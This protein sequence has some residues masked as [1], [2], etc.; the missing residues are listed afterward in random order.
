LKKIKTKASLTLLNSRTLKSLWFSWK[1]E[2]LYDQL[3]DFCNI[4]R[5]MVMFRILII[6]LI[7][8]K[9]LFLFLITSK[10]WF[11]LTHLN[12]LELRWDSS[13]PL[14]L[15]NSSSCVGWEVRTFKAC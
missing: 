10:H 3:F 5:T 13:S 14:P 1:K 11:T 2:W 15:L 12:H 7:T 9:G 8:V 4:L 6:A